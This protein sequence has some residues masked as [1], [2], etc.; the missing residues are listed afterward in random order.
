MSA[1]LLLNLIAKINHLL[2][3]HCR[4]RDKIKFRKPRNN[5]AFDSANNFPWPCGTKCTAH[6]LNFW[7]VIIKIS[8]HK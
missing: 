6:A 5:V 7:S 1:I 4:R 2:I 3:R 8:T